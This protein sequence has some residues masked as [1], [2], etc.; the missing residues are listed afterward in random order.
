MIETP[1]LDIQELRSVLTDAG[2]TAVGL[3]TMAAKKANDVRLDFTDR[4]EDQTK[5]LRSNLLTVV[6]KFDDARSKVEARVEPVIESLTARLPAPARK[7]VTNLTESAKDAQAKA[8]KLVVDALTV[9][10]VQPA[11][12]TTTVSATKIA[13]KTVV[14]KKVVAKTVAA[15]KVVAKK[16]LAEKVAAKK[17]VAKN[18]VAKKAAPKNIVAKRTAAKKTT[19]AKPAARKAA[20][21]K[22]AS[23]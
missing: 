12:K 3:A 5:D 13:P 14:A 21:R 1:T 2:H 19:T 20:A 23:A 10:I 7:V 22:V 15:K 9:E 11:V 6:E 17:V 8:H 16:V 4:Y 18:V